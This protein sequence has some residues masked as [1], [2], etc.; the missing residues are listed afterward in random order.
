MGKSWVQFEPWSI[1][2]HCSLD[3]LYNSSFLSLNSEGEKEMLGLSLAFARLSQ[4]CYWL[5]QHV[6]L[7]GAG[8]TEFVYY[9][10]CFL[11]II[12]RIWYSSPMSLRPTQTALSNCYAISDIPMRGRKVLLSRTLEPDVP[13]LKTA[14]A[15]T[16]SDRE[17]ENK[18]FNNS[19]NSA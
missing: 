3:H 14:P 4:R 11:F 13:W 12:R 17:A 16:G 19:D 15:S 5:V 8:E 10:L 1:F 6:L 9:Y 18:S 7:E 2:S